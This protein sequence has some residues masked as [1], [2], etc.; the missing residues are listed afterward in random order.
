MVPDS[1]CKT[2]IFTVSAAVMSEIELNEASTPAV[3]PRKKVRSLWERMDIERSPGDV[4]A[5]KITRQ[6]GWL[7]LV[8]IPAQAGLQA[9][10]GLTPGRLTSANGVPS[11]RAQKTVRKSINCF[12]M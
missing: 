7:T 9:H 8:A 2:P 11:P 12:F 5:V 1:E 4:R 3:V 10:H 6:T